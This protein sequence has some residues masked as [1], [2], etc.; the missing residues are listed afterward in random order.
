MIA[1]AILEQV[2]LLNDPN[3][4]LT[5]NFIFKKPNIKKIF[6]LGKCKPDGLCPNNCNGNGTCH[7]SKFFYDI[8]YSFFMMIFLSNFRSKMS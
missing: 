1:D 4:N 3:G 8:Y 7:F 5:V 6:C 2:L